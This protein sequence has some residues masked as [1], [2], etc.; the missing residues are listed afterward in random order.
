MVQEIINNKEF[1][2]II[3]SFFAVVLPLWQ[4]LGSKRDEQRQIQF[5]NYHD[6]ILKKLANLK[7]EESVD[8]QVAVIYEMRNYFKYYD[9]SKRRLIALYEKWKK[10]KAD[11]TIL[12]EI[13]LTI[14]YIDKGVILRFFVR[15]LNNIKNL[16]P[17]KTDLN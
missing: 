9:L 16:F 4:F 10:E 6:K 15:L 12:E 17:T 8:A 1:I 11:P 13:K 3:I 5:L 7:Q 14:E 2:A